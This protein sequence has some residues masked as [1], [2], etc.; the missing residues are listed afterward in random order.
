MIYLAPH[1]LEAAL[2]IFGAVVH[3]YE[4]GYQVLNS[5][6][7]VK[8]ALGPVPVSEYV[9]SMVEPIGAGNVTRV[10]PVAVMVEVLI[11]YLAAVLSWL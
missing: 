1:R 10:L 2:E 6:S 3:P 11:E 4:G 7:T 8:V 5:T 9:T